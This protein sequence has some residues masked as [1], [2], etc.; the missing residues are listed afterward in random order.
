MDSGLLSVTFKTQGNKTVLKGLG[1]R[2]VPME[3][4]RK[5]TDLQAGFSGKYPSPEEVMLVLHG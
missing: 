5:V 3:T 2:S 1:P 4:K